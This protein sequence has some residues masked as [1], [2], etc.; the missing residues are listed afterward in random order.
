MGFPYGS[1]GEETACNAGDLSLL[2]GLGRS[3]GE[4]KDYT[5]Q[6]SGQVNSM[7]YIVY[8]ITKSQTRLSDFQ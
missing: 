7:D 6:Y 5:L 8:G 1:A 2:P 4:E 3:H